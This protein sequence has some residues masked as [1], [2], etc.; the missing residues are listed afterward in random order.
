[1]D[2]DGEDNGDGKPSFQI[3]ASALKFDDDLTSPV[4]GQLPNNF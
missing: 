2:Q 1:M 4:G 3:K